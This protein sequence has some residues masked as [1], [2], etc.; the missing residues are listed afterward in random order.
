M[1]CSVA[2]VDEY[3]RMK[4]SCDDLPS[5]TIFDSPNKAIFYSGGYDELR[6][7]YADRVSRNVFDCDLS[8]PN[9]PE[10][11]VTMVQ[12][13]AS[14]KEYQLDTSETSEKV[15]SALSEFEDLLQLAKIPS[16]HKGILMIFYRRNFLMT[17]YNGVNDKMINQALPIFSSLINHSCDPNID[18]CISDG[19]IVAVVNRPVKADDQIF[20]TFE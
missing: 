10:T 15:R 2:C 20:K 18:I 4:D 19:R 8:D 7:I 14:L 11:R 12:C 3:H 6:E 13:A 17:V 1:F 16:R 5:N 9:N